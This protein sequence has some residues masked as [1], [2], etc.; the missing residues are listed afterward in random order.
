MSVTNTDLIDGDALE[1]FQRRLGKSPRNTLLDL[2]DRVPTDPQMA[3]H[4]CHGHVPREFQYVAV[5]ALV[6]RL[7]GSAKRIFT[8]RITP[9]TR[10]E[11]AE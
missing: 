7:S 6:Y 1:R 2:F 11:P 4:I 8:C 5:K 9:Q 3:S 10:K